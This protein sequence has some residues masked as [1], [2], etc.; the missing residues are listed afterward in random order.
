MG[1]L[2]HILRENTTI[3]GLNTTSIRVYLHGLYCMAQYILHIA[4]YALACMIVCDMDHAPQGRLY[5]GHKLGT[6][7]CSE[8]L[9]IP[10]V[11]CTMVLLLLRYSTRYQSFH[12]LHPP[13]GGHQALS[14]HL[15]N[16]PRHAPWG[17]TQRR[18]PESYLL[19]Q[20]RGFL[21]VQVRLNLD[22]ADLKTTGPSPGSLLAH[23][24]LPIPVAQ[25][26]IAR[27]AGVGHVV[28]VP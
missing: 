8:F 25:L 18:G 23:R 20:S 19:G 13:H 17:I 27:M 15:A 3:I 5:G 2:F 7:S 16:L 9:L 24:L 10:T 4:G 6:I 26:L 21:R 1:G 22:L 28:K 11:G 14:G 12:F